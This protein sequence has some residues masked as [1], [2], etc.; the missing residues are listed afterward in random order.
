MPLAER[1]VAADR[2]K[3]SPSKRLARLALAPPAKPDPQ[4]ARG[5]EEW[6][7]HSDEE[8]DLLPPGGSGGA[9]VRRAAE[10][11][12]AFDF[13]GLAREREDA[14]AERARAP[15]AEYREAA[16]PPVLLLGIKKPPPPGVP[17][18]QYYSSISHLHLDGQRIAELNCVTV[19][20]LSR[21]CRSSRPPRSSL[22]ASL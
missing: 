18:R 21:A 3:S 7:A 6:A 19:R 11:S 10:P 8:G 20:A 22:G 16:L 17:R 2:A 12:S 15:P 5:D 9:R 4:A 14:A 1:N 13:S